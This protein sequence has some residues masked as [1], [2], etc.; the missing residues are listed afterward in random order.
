MDNSIHITTTVSLYNLEADRFCAV[1][2][3]LLEDH[4][5]LSNPGLT[6][7]Y[8]IIDVTINGESIEFVKQGDKIVL[9]EYSKSILEPGLMNEVQI[10]HE[11]GFNQSETKGI[12]P[13]RYYIEAEGSGRQPYFYLQ[14][15]PTYCKEFIPILEDLSLKANYTLNIIAPLNYSVYSLTLPI[16]ETIIVA[17][18]ERSLFHAALKSCSISFVPFSMSST[19]LDQYLVSEDSVLQAKLVQFHPTLSISYNLLSLVVG[20]FVEIDCANTYSRIPLRLIAERPFSSLLEANKKRLQEVTTAGLEFYMN[21]FQV[22][23]PFEK[24]DQ[25][26]LSDFQFNAMENPG[27]ICI[28]SHNLL[29]PTCKSYWTLINRD[30][31]I[32]H[33]MAHMWL[34]NLVTPKNWDDLWIK[35]ATAEYY[36]HL[37][38]REILSDSHIDASLV[39]A[40]DILINHVYRAGLNF[41]H[42]CYPFK[43]DSFPVCFKDEIQNQNLI[44]FYGTIIYQKGSIYMKNLSWILGDDLFHDLFLLLIKQFSFKTISTTQFKELA[45]VYIE[46]NDKEKEI[47]FNKWFESHIYKKGYPKLKVQEVIYNFDEKRVRAQIKIS[48]PKWTKTR[49]LILGKGGEI[50]IANILID[51]PLECCSGKNSW[52]MEH[53][54]ENVDFEPLCYIPN[55][56][57]DDFMGISLDRKTIVNLFCLPHNLQRFIE[58]PETKIVIIEAIKKIRNK[59]ENIEVVNGIL[60]MALSEPTGFLKELCSWAENDLEKLIQGQFMRGAFE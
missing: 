4:T 29:D 2:C 46:K 10:W 27:M 58:S 6:Y 11:S 43:K 9:Q 17:S 16:S 38:F 19:S 26:F 52:H 28:A 55:C 8:S 34:G 37:A 39:S 14:S 36:C 7:S 33:E 41:R 25:V 56:F 3:Y 22:E 45:L 40:R 18:D 15:E 20:D 53:V 42:E 5:L 47:E 51:P 60:S 31:M 24:Y 23:Y 32:L 30:R 1:S 13:Y 50:I 49:S 48:Y 35:E 44:D 12:G 57:F 59:I 54:I 21:H